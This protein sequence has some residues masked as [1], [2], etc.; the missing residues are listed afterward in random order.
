MAKDH[1][2]DEKRRREAAQASVSEVEPGGKEIEGRSLKQ[3]VS[4]RLEAQLL[5]EL[6]TLATERGASI[7]DLL[8]E[9]AVDLVARSRPAPV[10]ITLRSAGAQMT[11]LGWVAAGRPATSGMGQVTDTGQPPVSS[12][13]AELVLAS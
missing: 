2:E 8:R 12:G 7:S 3:M 11:V 5:G 10:H 4:V 9:A 13:T 1:L 6:R